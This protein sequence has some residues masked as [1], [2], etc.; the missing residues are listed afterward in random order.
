MS[1]FYR[2]TSITQDSR[3]INKTKKMI[4]SKNF[5]EIY[6]EKVNF[7]KV[8]KKQT[9]TKRKDR[10]RKIKNLDKPKNNRNPSNR[11]RDT[12]RHNNIIFRKL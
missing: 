5:P 7:P 4:N 1:N 10:P 8:T 9:E 6:S 11:R 3:Y 2:G 12:S